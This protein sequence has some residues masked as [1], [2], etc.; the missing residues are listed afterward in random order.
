MMGQN[1]IAAQHISN[2]D[3][4]AFDI[5]SLGHGSIGSL[6]AILY[7]FLSYI[8][9]IVEYINFSLKS[10]L[11]VKPVLHLESETCE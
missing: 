3:A 7:D 11:S 2:P 5:N 9:A 4:N 6:F 1:K 10:A 8:T